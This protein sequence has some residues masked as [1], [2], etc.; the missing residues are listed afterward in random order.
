MKIKIKRNGAIVIDY[1]GQVNGCQGSA[2]GR[3]KESH[4]ETK[5]K[6]TTE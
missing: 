1:C 2:N 4:D 3:S 5:P 6:A